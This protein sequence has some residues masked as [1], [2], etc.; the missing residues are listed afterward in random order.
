[1]GRLCTHFQFTI[2][3]VH[4]LNWHCSRDCALNAK[5]THAVPSDVVAA[6]VLAGKFVMDAREVE[7]SH[8]H[9]EDAM[10]LGKAGH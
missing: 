5:S 9:A 6:M 3:M 4:L 8:N 7:S 2:W 1:M 10:G